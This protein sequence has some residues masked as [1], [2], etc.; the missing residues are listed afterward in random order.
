MRRIRLGP[1][2]GFVF[3]VNDIT[4]LSPW[5]S[6]AEREH[7][8]TFK[9]LVQAG[10][11]VVDVGANWGLHTLYLSRLVSHQGTVI[12]IEPFPPAFAELQ[13]HTQAN[14]CANVKQLCA[15]VSDRDGEAL[16]APGDDASTGRLSGAANSSTVERNSLVVKTHR[17]DSILN[18][19]EIEAPRMIKIVVEGA[20]SNVLLGAE[21]TIRRHRPHLVVDLQTPE[22]DVLVAGFLTSWRYRLERLSGPPILRTNVGWP[23]PEGVWGSTLSIGK[24]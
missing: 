3:R 5:Y 10:D 12:S 19:L 17:L 16:F 8:R 21:E 11:V 2:R 9:R 1:L 4:G 20:E 15:A 18:D 7:Q 13:W 24:T 23:H 14:D 22:Q 6:G